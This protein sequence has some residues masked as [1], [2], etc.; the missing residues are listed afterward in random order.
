MLS[1]RLISHD[2]RLHAHHVVVRPAP[3]RRE[4]WRRGSRTLRRTATTRRG[5]RPSKQPCAALAD[6]LS[7]AIYCQ[8]VA[9]LRADAQRGGEVVQ[10]AAKCVDFAL[11]QLA[12]A[13]NTDGRVD[14]L[15]NSFSSAATSVCRGDSC[16]TNLHVVY[17]A[18][19]ID[20]THPLT[21]S[22]EYSLDGGASWR[23]AGGSAF[24]EQHID[25]GTDGAFTQAP[26]R[27]TEA[28]ITVV[29]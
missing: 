24:Y 15:L 23:S 8:P 26:C 18:T 13:N 25:L 3:S 21:A 1:M 12:R 22:G 7:A 2:F 10:T 17:T 27:R 14:L 5:A 29:R 28:H 4:S 6:E 11:P 16:R 19:S 20:P 9:V